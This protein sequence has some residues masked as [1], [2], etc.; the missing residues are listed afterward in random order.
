M[1]IAKLFRTGRTVSK[2]IQ[3]IRLERSGEINFLEMSTNLGEAVVDLFVSEGVRIT[4]DKYGTYSGTSDSN[5]T[6]LTLSKLVDDQT[7]DPSIGKQ[8]RID[9]LKKTLWKDM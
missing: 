5:F 9:G 1:N 3:A 6:R 4:D 7:E 2:V 8:V